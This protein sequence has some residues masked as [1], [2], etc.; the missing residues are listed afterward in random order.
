MTIGERISRTRF[1]GGKTHV[2]G[3]VRV[4]FGVLLFW[5]GLGAARDLESVGYFGDAFH[6]P[7]LPEFLVPSRAFY[8]FLLATQLVLAALVT[9]GHFARPALLASA[10]LV[11]YFLLCDRLH[12]H[13]NRYAL[14]C[15]ALLLSLSPCDRSFTVAAHEDDEGHAPLW[16][17][18]LAQLQCSIIYL[19]SGGSKLLDPDWRSGQVLFDR[20]ARFGYQALERGVPQRVVDVF[21]RAETT[22][23]LAKLAI[24]TELFLAIALWSRKTRVFALWWGVWFHLVIEGTSKVE[25]FTWL[26]LL[27]YALFATHDTAA[28]KLRWDPLRAK[29]RWVGRVVGAL[30]WLARFEKKPWDPD[31]VGGGRHVVIVDRDGSR[32]T[33]LRAVALVA[34]TCPLLFPLWAPLALAASFT[35]SARPEGDEGEP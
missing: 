27:V 3:L 15:Y 23:V 4:G 7:F 6:M 14:A 1:E 19:A 30:D 10:L 24:G 28:R 26:T 31:D 16:A 20:F 2:I 17:V 13:H 12:F 22:S 5:Q 18:R 35:K 33:G 29:G 34:R 11:L 9:V 21:S 25:S 32:H 8:T